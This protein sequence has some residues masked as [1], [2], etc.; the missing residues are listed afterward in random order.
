MLTSILT[1][2]F[3]IDL[4]KTM[5]DL[6]FINMIKNRERKQKT[7]TRKREQKRQIKFDF[8]QKRIK[9][10]C[11]KRRT[12]NS[13]NKEYSCDKFRTYIRLFNA[14]NNLFFALL[15]NFVRIFFDK[16]IIINFVE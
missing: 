2:S 12:T 6:R 16:S 15:S 7:R 9:N 10:R 13:I 11:R 4:V 14:N 8:E 3:I 1:T 5:F